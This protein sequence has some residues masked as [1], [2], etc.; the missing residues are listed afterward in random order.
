MS[1]LDPA[2]FYL[3]ADDELLE[4]VCIHVDDI[5]WSGIEKFT[6]KLVESFKESFSIWAYNTDTFKYI[7]LNI[8][9]KKTN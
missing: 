9:Q 3:N 4:I 5:F 7:G 1:K 6:S 8:V 2:F